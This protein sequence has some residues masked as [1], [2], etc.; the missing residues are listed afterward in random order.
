MV[1]KSAE[2][3]QAG[4]RRSLVRLVCRPL[5]AGMLAVCALLTILAAA[6]AY[7]AAREAGALW[8]LFLLAALALGVSA[9]AV[10]LLLGYV[11]RQYLIPLSDA[12]AAAALAA[13][14]DMTGSVSA[15]RP[16]SPEA[17][18][19]LEAVKDLESRSTACLTEL[20]A[21]LKRLA[22][23]D[24]ATRMNCR[25]TAECRGVCAAVDGTAEK[26]RGAVGTVR[27]ALEQLAASLDALEE[28]AGSLEA[29]AGE[30]RQA[31]ES[32][33]RTLER[34]A[35]QLR[36]QAGQ[37]EDVRCAAE[38]LGSLLEECGR[39]QEA[40]SQ[41][42]ERI[43]ECSAEAGQ[44]VKAMEAA[45][46]QCSVLARTAYVEAAGAGVNGKGFAVVASELRMLASRSAQ[47][48][49]DAAAFMEEM[50]RTVR[51]SASLAAAASREVRGLTAA[52]ESI[53]RQAAGAALEAG[54]AENMKESLRQ[55]AS[56]GGSAEAC[57]DRSGR[58]ARTA[59]LLKSRVS[60][61]RDALGVFRLR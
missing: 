33:L 38:S 43:G 2:Q 31:G 52:G 50:N 4:E 11:S 35:G 5:A 3:K 14:G 1:E 61:L 59:R 40:L 7:P 22:S 15:I 47:A 10:V 30:R 45:S 21:A 25:R 53:R 27:T 58:A 46:F 29:D 39:R 54:Q 17:A 44:I 8:L 20:E 32:L 41:A 12:A 18:S 26:L 6:A 34:M 55:A 19:L 60:R 57:L 23:G 56:L 24:L 16:T 42:V 37:A 51:E 9:G 49:Q 36:R 48:A 13:A 28:D